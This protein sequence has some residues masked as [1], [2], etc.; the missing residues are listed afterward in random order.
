MGDV[1][2]GGLLIGGGACAHL[3]EILLTAR[4]SFSDSVG[5]AVG[6]GILRG[7]CLTSAASQADVDEAVE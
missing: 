2:T 1:A 5:S 7:T 4:A 3:G 6:S